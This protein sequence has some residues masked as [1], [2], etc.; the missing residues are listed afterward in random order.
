MIIRKNL[1]LI[2]VVTLSVLSAAVPVA[3]T[4]PS[5]AAQVNLVGSLLLPQLV[6][7]SAWMIMGPGTMPVRMSL[8]VLWATGLSFLVYDSMM[9][10][11]AKIPGLGLPLVNYQFPMAMNAAIRTGLQFV[12]SIAIIAVLRSV[13]KLKLLH[14]QDK[15]T[16]SQA[17]TSQFRISDLFIAITA[18]SAVFLIVRQFPSPHPNG[19]Y[20]HPYFNVAASSLNKA[21]GTAPVLIALMM[22]NTRKA[23]KVFGTIC[24][25]SAY[26]VLAP[27]AYVLTGNSRDFWNN[28]MHGLLILPWILVAVLI[29]RWGGYRLERESDI[30]N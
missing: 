10:S 3:V 17:S 14:D 13:L 19:D 28:F 11:L 27:L 25:F 15:G 24:A 20:E 4:F 8:A 1:A 22:V 12:V 21:I 26:S 23:W 29:L 2:G 9:Q 5:A 6:I 18:A 16:I 30:I 7:A